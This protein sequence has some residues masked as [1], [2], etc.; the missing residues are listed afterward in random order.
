MSAGD[1][2]IDA[3]FD[4]TQCQESSYG[5]RS[6]GTNSVRSIDRLIFHRRIPPTIKQK[7]VPAELQVKSN[8]PG[9]IA[10]QKNWSVGVFFEF[11]EDRVT[12]L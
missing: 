1:L 3:L 8:T 11:F 5:H 12:L 6:G 2:F 4:S 9:P 7:N 10:H